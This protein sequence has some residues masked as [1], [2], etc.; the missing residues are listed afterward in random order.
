MLEYLDHV[1]L[2]NPP[3]EHQCFSLKFT[4]NGAFSE[5]CKEQMEHDSFQRRLEGELAVPSF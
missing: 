3:T 4:K 1:N 2:A 5:S